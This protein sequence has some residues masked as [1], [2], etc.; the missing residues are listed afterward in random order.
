VQPVT[1]VSVNAVD[2]RQ[3]TCVMVGG[4][5]LQVSK[6][7]CVTPLSSRMYCSCCA[8]IA[9]P[10]AHIVMDGA[11]CLCFSSLRSHILL[12]QLRHEALH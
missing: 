7:D 12:Q 6:H 9:R 5:V 2:H 1:V 3:T 4:A 8:P 11:A 10:V